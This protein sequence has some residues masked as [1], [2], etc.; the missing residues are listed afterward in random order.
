MI[1]PVTAFPAHFLALL[2]LAGCGSADSRDIPSANAATFVPP[3]DVAATPLPGQTPDTPATAYAGKLPNDPVGG[4][5][6]FDRTDVSK[7][8]LEAVRDNATRAHFRETRGPEKPIYIRGGK[9]TAAGCNAQDCSG[10][11][12]AFLFDPATKTGEACLHDTATM[13]DSS[14]WF[15]N[16]TATMRSGMC[17]LA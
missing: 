7:A 10:E 11:N 5:L 6:F 9:V 14:R 12:W 16:G 2:L 4:V 3:R 17:P 15:S 8:L 1:K 13:Q